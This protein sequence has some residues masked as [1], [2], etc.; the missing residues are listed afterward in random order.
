MKLDKH[1]KVVTE[2][3]KIKILFGLLFVLA[4]SFASFAQSVR[5]TP[6]KVTYK[7]PKPIADYK[8]TFTVTYPIVKAATPA[9]SRKIE[10]TISYEKVSNLNIEEEKGEIQWLEE[11]DYEVKYNKNG[12]LTITLFVTGTGAY[13]STFLKTVV[14]DLKT[15]NRVAPQDVFT[16]LAKLAAKAKEKQKAEV[17]KSL[18]EIKSDPANKDYDDFNFFENT[19]FTVENLEEFAV[20]D[21]GVTFIYDYGFPHVIFALQPDGKYFFSWAELKP[22]IRRGGLLAKFIR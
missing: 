14:V 12:I 6:K 15:G 16:N 3:M 19:D 4:F 21:K 2:N 11:A 1:K 22:F 10:R 13:P 8:K 17:E 5:I 18:K 9:L 20:D 7:R